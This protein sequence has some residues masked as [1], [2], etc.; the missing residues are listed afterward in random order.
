ME[1]HC[2]QHTEI[3]F[4]FKS[5]MNDADTHKMMKMKYGNACLAY[6][7]VFKWFGRFRKGWE[8]VKDEARPRCPRTSRTVNNI[9]CMHAVLKTDRRMSIR[10][11]VDNLNIEKETSANNNGRIREKKAFV[12]F[13]PHILTVE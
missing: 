4:C 7:N 8:S 13:I 1:T 5:G 3:K 12:H 6:L 10:I 2:K 11:L 9:E